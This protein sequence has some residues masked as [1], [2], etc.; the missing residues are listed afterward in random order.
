MKSGHITDSDCLF[1]DLALYISDKYQEVGVELGLKG[2]VL[3][4][5]L[6]TGRLKMEI[7]SKKALKMLQLWRDSVNKDNCTYSV[8]AAAL[9]KHGF[10]RCA[11]S[12]CYTSSKSDH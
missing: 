7:G 10:Q 2:E 9:E 8:L 3:T 5:E 11:D 4:D 1:K 12:F 6:E